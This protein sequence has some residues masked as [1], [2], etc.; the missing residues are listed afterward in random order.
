MRLG[1][2]RMESRMKRFLPILLAGL[3]MTAGK[4]QAQKNPPLRLVQTIPLPDVD[5]RIDHFGVD[6]QRQR[7]FMSALGN[8]TVEV[9]DLGAGKRIYSIKGLHE[10][11]GVFYVPESNRIFVAGGVDVTCKIF[12][13]DS[14]ALL[15][16]LPSLDD[17]DNL[18]YDA[19][20]KQVWV[21][22]GSGALGDLDAASGDRMGDAKLAAH[23]ESFQLE[24][25][26]ARVFVNVPYAGHIAVIDRTKRAILA[27]WPTGDARANFPMALD[28]AHHR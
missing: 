27:T 13:G 24:A 9:F 12:D 23:P 28:E 16:T 25:S 20:R 17:A 18:R 4:A 3:A 19:A 5:G 8:G 26:G 6:I 1:S 15:R 2:S 21:G 10:P 14:Y 22:Y 11:Q 7:L